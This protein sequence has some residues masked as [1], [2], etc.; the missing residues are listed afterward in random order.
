MRRNDWFVQVSGLCL[1]LSVGVQTV[2]LNDAAACT[3]R[4]GG[5]NFQLPHGSTSIPKDG[6]LFIEN[7]CSDCAPLSEATFTV[8]DEAGAAVAGSL[9]EIPA[10]PQLMVWRPS[11]TFA[12]GKYTLE[13]NHTDYDN[14]QTHVFE[15]RDALDVAIPTP[16]LDNSSWEELIGSSVCCEDGATNSCGDTSCYPIVEGVAP[17]ISVGFAFEYPD[18]SAP[19]S[20]LFRARAQGAGWPAFSPWHEVAATFEQEAAE[21]CYEI[22]IQDMRAGGELTEL[23]GCVSASEIPPIIKQ[24]LP[25]IERTLFWGC[26]VPPAGYEARW[27]EGFADNIANGSCDDHIRKSSCEAALAACPTNDN[28]CSYAAGRP[29]SNFAWLFASLGFLGLVKRRRSVGSP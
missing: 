27:C 22:Q 25:E 26:S 1:L 5:F 23:E 24:D 19:Q 15:V 18:E 20:F 7:L 21:Y 4:P 29:S 16:V 13:G 28:S 2:G 8:V 3:P 9:E 10:S 6:V 17:R 11:T 12:S 14:Q